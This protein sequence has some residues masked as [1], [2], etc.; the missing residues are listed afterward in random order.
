M[1][2]MPKKYRSARV[3]H[4]LRDDK[5]DAALTNDIVDF[6]GWRKGNNLL[7]NDKKGGILY[8]QTLHKGTHR[9]Y[10]VNES[11]GKHSEYCAFSR[12]QVALRQFSLDLKITV[13]FLSYDLVIQKDWL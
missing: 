1:T 11:L 5:I 9:I 6:K 12:D 4:V 2:L 10:I 13:S 3:P 7:F 8:C